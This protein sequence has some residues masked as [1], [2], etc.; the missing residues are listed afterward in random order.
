MRTSSLLA[1]AAA[2]IQHVYAAPYDAEIASALQGRLRIGDA[3]FTCR[4]LEAVLGSEVV[5]TSQDLEYTAQEQ[6]NYSPTCWL[7][8]A[9]FVSPEDIDQVSA[10]V[11]IIGALQTPFSIRSGGKNLNPGFASV[12]ESGVLLSLAKLTRLE[13]AEDEGSLNIGPG[14][15]WDEV[16]DFVVPKGLVVV[17]SRYNKVGVPGFLLG[18]GI[19]FYT[20]QY[21]VAIDNIKSF[22]VVLASGKVAVASSSKHCDLYRA[23][24]GGNSNF[25]VVVN[26]ELYTYPH[27]T[28]HWQTRG[29]NPE[30]AGAILEAYAEFQLTG[31]SDP[32]ARVDM[33]IFGDRPIII[34]IYN[35][36]APPPGT[37][38]AFLHLTVPFEELVP[39]TSGTYLELQAIQAIR[40][41]KEHPHNYG[42]TFSHTI[43]GTYMAEIEQLFLE[44]MVEPS[45]TYENFS[46]LWVPVAMPASVARDDN[47]L[48]IE[49]VEQQWHEWMIEWDNDEYNDAMLELGHNI[50]AVLTAATEEAGTLLPYLFMNTAGGSQPVLQSYGEENVAFMKAV[51]KRYDPTAV[52]Q[53]QFGG[54]LLRDL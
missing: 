24:K 16:Y 31:M 26:F 46:F 48:G 19:S 13:L 9:C 3:G 33:N 4:V 49:P 30:D 5:V 11:R 2:S 28:L 40:F 1:V 38:D 41:V 29:Y 17:G 25:G 21:G 42:E 22:T 39:P 53:R 12:D 10:A 14:V 7:S 37:F 32:L 36:G 51:A 20:N 18:G 27:E 52:F 43:D 50:T 47:V 8:A 54:W 44:L 35:G 45:N 6:A 15:L 23:L 34:M